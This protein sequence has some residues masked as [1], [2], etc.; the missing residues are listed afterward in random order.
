MSSWVAPSYEPAGEDRGRECAA[1]PFVQ[2]DGREGDEDEDR[3]ER[4]EEGDPDGVAQ[5]RWR[6]G[7]LHNGAGEQE[8]EQ[9]EARAEHS[10]GYWDA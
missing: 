4:P 1:E 10:R 9:E 2:V 3:R 5:P 6:A 8:D 7:D